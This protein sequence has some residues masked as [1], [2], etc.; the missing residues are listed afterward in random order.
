MGVATGAFGRGFSISNLADRGRPLSPIIIRGV[1]GVRP[2]RFFL[3]GVFGW[4]SGVW[5]REGVGSEGPCCGRSR[6][7]FDATGVGREE[8]PPSTSC[9]AMLGPIPSSLG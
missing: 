7:S 2:E 4:N 3:K 8:G 5:E 9:A 1:A 6:G